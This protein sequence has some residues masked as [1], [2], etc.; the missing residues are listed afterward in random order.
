VL[1]ILDLISGFLRLTR[2]QPNTLMQIVLVSWI[3]I[4][5]LAFVMIALGWNDL[6]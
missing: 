2:G 3:A 6:D 1:I 4:D 5:C